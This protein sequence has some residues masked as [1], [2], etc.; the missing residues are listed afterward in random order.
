MQRFA[1]SFTLA[2]IP[3]S[4]KHFGR[5]GLPSHRGAVVVLSTG[6]GGGADAANRC[7][8]QA[9]ALAVVAAL[10]AG[11][12]QVETLSY[13]P[14]PANSPTPSVTSPPVT[15][16]DS[17]HVPLPVVAGATTTM[18]PAAR[19]GTASISGAVTGPSGPVAGAIV[20]AE[21]IVGN[22]GAVVKGLTAAD[23]SFSL[24]GLLGGDY[25][26]RAWMAPTLDL[27]D[28]QIFYLGAGGAQ[29]L[30]LQLVA[31]GGPAVV[32]VMVPNTPTLDEPAALAVQVTTPTVGHDGVIR[33]PA[34]AGALVE[35]TDGPGWLVLNANPVT[36]AS[37]GEAIF[38]LTCVSLGVQ[39]LD[40]SVNG[41]VAQPLTVPNCV[42]PPTPTTSTSVASTT[43]SST[44]PGTATTSSTTT[45]TLSP[46]AT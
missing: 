31:V 41:Q 13:A 34:T 11:C 8:R 12:T 37:N 32:G 9:L 5:G 38:S 16:A 6:V 30:T 28:P 45:S 42:A 7:G 27:T 10:S 24:P 25:R 29:V 19:G 22:R 17:S 1:M 40:A 4:D 3:P 23:G 20:Q 21:R 46:P 39:P 43:T 44:A 33:N 35:L 14:P 15:L 36:T 26:V 2:G 18:P